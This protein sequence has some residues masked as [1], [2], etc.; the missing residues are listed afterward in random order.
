MTRPKINSFSFEE[1]LETSITGSH[2]P[3]SRA[4]YTK[5]AA[6]C[7]SPKELQMQHSTIFHRAVIALLACVICGMHA[8][9]GPRDA[10]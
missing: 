8:R 6:G 9:V 10:G 2:F 5:A 3:G 7:R 4:A 1:M